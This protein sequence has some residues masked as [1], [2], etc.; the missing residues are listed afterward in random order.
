MSVDSTVNSEIPHYCA[1]FFVLGGTLKIVFSK[2]TTKTK[3][4][5]GAEDF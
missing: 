2:V 5:R 4:R 1:G 3:N